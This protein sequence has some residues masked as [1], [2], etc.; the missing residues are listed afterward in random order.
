MES[1]HNLTLPSNGSTH[2]E[3][4]TAVTDRAL[5]H[6]S[7][8]VRTSSLESYGIDETKLTQSSQAKT[9]VKLG[10]SARPKLTKADSQSTRRTKPTVN[11]YLAHVSK[12]RRCTPAF[13]EYRKKQRRPNRKTGEPV[14]PDDLEEAFHEGGHALDLMLD[15]C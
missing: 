1:Y 7:G 15:L 9:Y 6:T 8:N 12:A 5:R 13:L 3:V 14:W 11:V 2:L 4:A 10:T